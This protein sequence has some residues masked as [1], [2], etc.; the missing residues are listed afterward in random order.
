MRTIKK[1]VVKDILFVLLGNVILSIGVGFF[2]VPNSVLSAG[3]A[4]LA[5]SLSPFIKF[6]SATNLITLLTVLLFV[7]G[8]LVLGKHFAIKTLISSFVY[9]LLVSAIT[10]FLDG[11]TLTDNMMLASFYGG[12]IVGIGVGLVFR[13]GGST[14]G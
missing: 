9:P 11:A 10:L 1:D 14:G 13:G 6:I 2:I 3:V 12:A 8:A 4:G 7:I 5:V